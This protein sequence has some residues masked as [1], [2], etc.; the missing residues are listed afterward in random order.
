MP[1]L[2]YRQILEQAWAG[3]H[4]PSHDL[5]HVERVLH[6][7][8]TIFQQEGGRWDIIEPSVWFHDLVN[9]PKNH[10]NRHKASALSAGQALTLLKENGISDEMHLEQIH[11]AIT[12]HS[13]S[14]AIVPET[15]EAKI[16]Q[17]ADRLDS[18]GALGIM[19][20]FA[21]SGALDRPFFDPE[22]PFAE[23]RELDDKK[24]ALDHFGVKLFKIAGTLH[25]KTATSMAQERLRFMREFF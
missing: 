16:V 5:S 23:A 8:R 4:D 19:R 11:H 13:F 7:A 9:V 18:L 21:V 25:T 17:D 12:A 3:L 10:P 20:T 15:L 22:D 24:F 14:A 1:S 6:N 2:A